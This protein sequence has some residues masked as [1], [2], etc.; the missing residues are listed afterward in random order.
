MQAKG[1]DD[2]HLKSRG[3]SD[4]DE[5]QM[6]YYFIG[7]LSMLVMVHRGSGSIHATVGPKGLDVY[8]IRA[9]VSQIENWGLGRLVLRTDKEPAILALATEIRE[10]R[11][12]PTIVE[13]APKGAHQAVGGVERANQELGKQIRALKLGLEAH[14]GKLPEDHRVMAWLAR[15]AAWLV[16][17]Y[18]VHSSTG[19]TSFELLRGKPYRGELVEF[20]ELVWAREVSPASKMSARWVSG[21]WLGKAELSD[22]HLVGTRTKT[23]LVR[24]IRRRPEAERFNLEELGRY[25]GMPWDLKEK[26]EDEPMQ[27][28]AQ[29]GVLPAAAAAVPAV[30]AGI[31]AGS[32]AVPSADGAAPTRAMYVTKAL[33]DKYGKSPGCSRCQLGVGPHT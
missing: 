22:E 16:C 12:A 27:P 3:E 19:K 2:K 17:R 32:E 25:A 14:V 23:Q 13:S 4:V 11:S 20:G 30:V 9:A 6:D 33:T 10:K 1:I 15:H 31:P 21:V 5:V 24:S 26:G 8:M 18:T 7:P 29:P 28:V